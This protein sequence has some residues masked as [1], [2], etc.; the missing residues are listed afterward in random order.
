[1]KM[2]VGLGNPGLKYKATRHNMGFMVIDGLCDKYGFRLDQKK[3]NALY[4]L[5]KIR[6]EKVLLVKPLTFMNNSGE[7]VGALARYYEIDLED[8]VVVYDDLDLPCGKLRLRNSGDSGGHKGIKSLISHL[9][10][11]D[12]KRIRVGIDK[13]QLM[14]T[15]D[16]VLGKP[17]SEQKKLL[18]PTIEKAVMAADEFIDNDFA[19]VMNKYNKHE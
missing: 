17:N 11:K 3:F 8:V 18:K 15:A 6:K 12:F 5:A 19:L 7:A 13:D 4:G 9:G 2:I 1:M 14:E 10:S 16:Y